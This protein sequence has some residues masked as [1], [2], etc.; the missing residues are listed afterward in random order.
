MTNH[1]LLS[2]SILAILLSPLAAFGG[3]TV[4]AAGTTLAPGS[5]AV[6]KQT[7][8]APGPAAQPTKPKIVKPPSLDQ[9]KIKLPSLPHGVVGPKAKA[10]PV[11]ATGLWK[12]TRRNRNG[13]FVDVA[14]QIAVAKD[15]TI[16][17]TLHDSSGD[18]AI[19]KPVLKG[20]SLT[21]T[22]LYHSPGRP[23]VPFDYTVTLDPNNPKVGIDRPDFSPAGK[24]AGRKLHRE[25]AASH[26]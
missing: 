7:G 11:S 16:T 20:D 14:L 4:T 5:A 8:N 3:I 17:G 21:F 13:Q 23:D 1:R 12:W 26:Q 22:V 10:S 15:G 19:Q 9:S 2:F 6:P 25:H 24:A 18:H